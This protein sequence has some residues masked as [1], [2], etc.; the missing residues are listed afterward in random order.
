MKH[1]FGQE[2]G[3]KAVV[4]ASLLLAACGGGGSSVVGGSTTTTISG[5]AVAGAVNGN[6]TVKDAVS[7]AVLASV[8]AVGGKFSVSLN[9]SALA[10][11]L[12]FEAT[13]SYIDE[14]SGQTVTLTVGNALRLRAAANQYT[15][16]V[17]GN[18][19]ITPDSTVIANLAALPGQT[20]TSAKNTY[21]MAFGY[22]PDMAATPF[23][24]YG[25]LPAGVPNT[26]NHAAAAFRAGAYSQWAMG[27]GLTAPVDIAGLP[28]AL[29]TDLL[30]GTLNGAN[31]GAPVMVGAVNLQALH[32][33]QKLAARWLVAMADFAGST[34]NMAGAKT[35]TMGF[36]MMAALSDAAG[37]T[38][39]VT[40][41]AATWNVTLTDS[42]TAPFGPGFNV[43]RTT[44]RI[45]VADAATGLPVNLTA[46]GIA[47][48]HKPWMHMLS[49]MGHSSEAG[50][51]DT[52]LAATGVLTGD[53]YYRMA[54]GM[55]MGGMTTPMGIWDYEVKFC[56][57]AMPAV[58]SSAIFHPE[59]KSVMAPTILTS[60]G[61]SPYDQTSNMMG[62]AT[63]RSYKVWLHAA[64][65]N[66]AG[67]H[68][69]SV[70]VATS[71]KTP[72]GGMGGMGGMTMG[73]FT[74]PAVYPT[75]TLNDSMGAVV[76]LATVV[77]EVSTDGGVTFVPMTEV[78]NGMMH[79]GIYRAVGLV[80]LTA[81]VLATPLVRLTVNGNAML[82]AAGANPS[83]AFT[84]P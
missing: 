50:M 56:T 3:R 16:G 27:L 8:P 26:S 63:N 41:G 61:S 79:T 52:A 68:D 69:L 58:C 6:V 60:A 4:A 28:A 11:E 14:A 24:P 21:N 9:N 37:T 25:A 84:A 54:T 51:L 78:M 66:L 40:V 76:T 18:A 44:H 77:V 20:L 30:D 33:Q 48:S 23:D 71:N 81:G 10:G 72:A 70:F 46:A 59:V 39:Q 31:A 65:P 15:S 55:T 80:G 67:G 57:G 38:R 62:M 75:Q 42:Y 5:A 47:A 7:G 13:G 53:V 73:G 29:A 2:M 43:A 32:A 64:T 82:T 1:S 36:P 19:P 35:P 17:A 74:F 45:A 22:T 83:L 12:L 34:K 49:G